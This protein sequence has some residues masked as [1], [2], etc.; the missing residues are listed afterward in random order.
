VN[1]D[2]VTGKKSLPIL[3]GLAQ[4][5]KFAK[6][7]LSG[8]IAPDEVDDIAN[9]LEIEGA[10]EFTQSEANRL[11]NSALTALD[12]AKP[13]G[14]AGEALKQLTNKLLLRDI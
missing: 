8:P 14:E 11:T 7:W 2:L 5:G 3:Y 12:Q 9:F 1:S 4:N 13:Q 6:R 10:R